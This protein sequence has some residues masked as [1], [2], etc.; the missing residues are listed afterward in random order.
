MY[1]YRPQLVCLYLPL[2]MSLLLTESE[3]GAASSLARTQH[4]LVLAKLTS[5]GAQFPAEFKVIP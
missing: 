2:L 5:I 4:E 3:E 1:L